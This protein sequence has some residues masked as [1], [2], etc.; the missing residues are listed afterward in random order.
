MKWILKRLI[1]LYQ[2]QI[3]PYLGPSKCRFTPT[4]SSYALEAVEVH[5]ALRGSLM[6]IWRILRCNP[7]GKGGYDPV[8]P[9]KKDKEN[10]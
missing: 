6:A 8:S 4:C 1:R 2:T 9:R 7:W 10:A 5:G 3:S